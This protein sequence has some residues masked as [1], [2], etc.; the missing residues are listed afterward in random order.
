MAKNT[1]KKCLAILDKHFS[2]VTSVAL[3]ED[4]WT[5]LSAGRDKVSSKH[6]LV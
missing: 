3:S 4:G 2:A 5:L 6:S 1:E